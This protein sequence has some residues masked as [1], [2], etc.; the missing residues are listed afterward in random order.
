[1]RIRSIYLGVVLLGATVGG[2]V[3]AQQ[4][5]PSKPIRI[6]V[7]YAAG[8]GTDIATRYL[9]DQMGKDLGQPIVVENKPGAGGNLGTEMTALAA[10]DGYTLTMG[11]NATHALNAF[12]YAK[13]PF[14]AERDFEPIGL[15]G[16]FPMI[17]A[18]N[19]NAPYTSLAQLLET[20]R[21]NPR[22]AD[23]AM[24]STTARLVVELLKERSSFPLFGVPYKG[25]GNAM[26]DVLG[27]QLP[28]IVDTPTALRSHLASGKVRAIAVTSEKASNLA[29]GVKTVSEQGYP[30]YEVVAWNALYAPR[31]TPAQVI[32][33]INA[34]MNKALARPETRQ[35]LLELGLEPAGG[36][37]GDLAN[38]AKSERTKWGPVIKSA[39]LKAD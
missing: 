10:P 21:G 36:A 17:V 5:Y 14:E 3:Q 22:S 20:A 29:P 33:T 31:G 34:A 18:V 24:P 39:G 32:A 11:T 37:P 26:T 15:V 9:A 27:G 7:A 23:I 19:T 4:P 8:Q 2:V 16:T 12:L 13:V 25:S 35:R 30:G 28:V 38:F 6:V 1:M